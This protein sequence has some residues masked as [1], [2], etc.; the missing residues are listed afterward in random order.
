MYA[1]VFDKE[2]TQTFISNIFFSFNQG[3]EQLR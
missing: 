3:S 1:Q 2:K